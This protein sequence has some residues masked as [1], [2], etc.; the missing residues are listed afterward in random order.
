MTMAKTRE[1][2]WVPKPRRLAERVVKHCY[3]CKRSQ[4]QPLRDPP[5][6]DLPK[7]PT[8]E[9]APFDVIG[10]NFTGPVKYLGKC[11]TEEKAYVVIYPWCLTR[12]IFLEVLPNLETG[13]FIKTFKRLIARRGRPFLVYSDNGSRFTAAANWLKKVKRMRSSTH[14]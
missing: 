8:E 2:F 14:S 10:V 6:G 5:P 7:S 3:G 11:K 12:G 4:A 1:T 13:E 9:S